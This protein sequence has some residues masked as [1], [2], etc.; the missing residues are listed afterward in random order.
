MDMQIW[1]I[2]KWVII[3]A[4]CT[5]VLFLIIVQIFSVR[6]SPDVSILDV[7]QGDAIVIQTPEYHNI[8]IDSGP[9][10]KTVDRLSEELSFFNKTIDVFILTHPHSDHYGGILDVMQKY[11]IRKIIMTGVAS[12]DPVYLAFLDEV[13]RQKIETIFIQNNRDIQ[14]GPNLY[15][16]IIYPLNN[17]N[18]IGQNVSNANNTSIV[19]RLLHLSRS[20]WETL[21]I[22]TGDAE[23]EEE[24]EILLAGQDVS[25]GILKLGHHGSKTATSDAFLRAVSPNTAVISVGRDNKFGHPHKETM[26]KLGDITIHQTMKEGSVSFSF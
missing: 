8:L 24:R 20:G 18:Y 17:Q 13:K 12:G 7:G 15:M 9:D 26:D 1:T 4:V 6:Q 10:S 14:I 16:D 21:A 3:H 11:H 5:G 19:A 25:A 2:K 22:L 23:S